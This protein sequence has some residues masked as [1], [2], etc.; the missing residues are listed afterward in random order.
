MKMGGVCA[1]M[2][3]VLVCGVVCA[4]LIVIS[5]IEVASISELA[6]LLDKNK[7]PTTLLLLLLLFLCSIFL[8]YWYCCL[9]Y[10]ASSIWNGLCNLTQ[11]APTLLHFLL[12]CCCCCCALVCVDPVVRSTNSAIVALL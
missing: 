3:I 9:S 2:S 8:L 4:Q 7:E 6:F 12:L 1:R 11:P 5:D 10:R